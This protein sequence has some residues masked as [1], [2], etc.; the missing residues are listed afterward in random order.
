M[1]RDCNFNRNPAFA[2]GVT[3]MWI[4]AFTV[5]VLE[6][7]GAANNLVH[8]VCGAAV[9]LTFIG[10]LYGSAKTRPLFD[11]FCA[12]KRRLLGRGAAN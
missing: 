10:L 2:I 9:G 5:N 3:L 8:F 4:G 12:F 7:E 11:R 1:K 6:L